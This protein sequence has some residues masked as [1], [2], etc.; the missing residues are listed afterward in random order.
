[1]RAENG[2][3]AKRGKACTQRSRT[4]WVVVDTGP[5]VAVAIEDDPDH[6]LCLEVLIRNDLHLVIPI[7]VV[8]EAAYLIGK[9]L[10]PTAEAAFSMSMADLDTEPSPARGLV[11]HGRA[12]HHLP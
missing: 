9:R 2:T 3:K 12:H 5:L 11:A 8:A 4:R 10:D 7:F 1:M 6:A